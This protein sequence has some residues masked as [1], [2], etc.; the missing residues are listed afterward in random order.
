[1]I[2]EQRSYLCCHSSKAI[3]IGDDPTIK[4]IQHAIY[5]DV[6]P[7]LDAERGIPPEWVHRNIEYLPGHLAK[8]R[9][10]YLD[11]VSRLE[12]NPTG[13]SPETGAI[14][15]ALGSCIVDS[16][17]LQ[18]ALLS[19][20]TMHDRQRI[21]E[22]LDTAEALVVEA[23]LALSK[24]GAE[25]LYAGEIAVEVNRL[26]EA[27]GEGSKLSPEKVG[28]RLRRL[29]LPTGRLSQA[30]NGLIMD[31]ETMTRLQTLSGMYVGEDLLAEAE[32]LHCSQ[33]TEKKEVEEVM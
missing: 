4:R 13:V 21:S 2:V 32:N 19:I 7:A 22:R 27:R 5:M 30:G 1:M 16:A 33:A 3:Y 26:V 8:Y 9:K 31:K 15:K 23:V 10:A 6:T 20:F 18:A 11:Q 28:H 17:A 25:H 29:G 24:R 14:V 12:F